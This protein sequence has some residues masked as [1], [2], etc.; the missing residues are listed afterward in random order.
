M[1]QERDQLGERLKATVDELILRHRL[2][3]EGLAT[4]RQE[5]SAALE[6]LRHVEAPHLTPSTNE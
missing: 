3:L 2:E 6:A 5:I 1:A 4:S